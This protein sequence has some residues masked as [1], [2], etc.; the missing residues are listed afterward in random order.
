MVHGEKKSAPR[1]NERRS[2]S[3]MYKNHELTE[4][5]FKQPAYESQELFQIEIVR[6]NLCQ[7]NTLQGFVTIRMT[8]IGLEIRHI[9][10]HEK[11]GNRWIQLPSKPYEKN[12]QTSWAYILDF[13][14][15]SKGEQFQRAVPAAFDSFLSS[16]KGGGDGL[17]RSCQ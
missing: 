16:G 4:I 7:S 11:P 2:T 3:E 14:D 10:M 1:G 17:Q 8:R 6:F 12:G 13:Y 5:T 9:A 15:K